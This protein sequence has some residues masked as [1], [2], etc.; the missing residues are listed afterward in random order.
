MEELVAELGGAFLCARAG[1]D[2][3]VQHA[4]YIAHWLRVLRADKKAIFTA[5]ARARDAATWL[6][7]RAGLEADGES[8]EMA[9]K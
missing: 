1:V 7:A 8:L 4:E 5:A 3:H 9:A 6:C 2:G